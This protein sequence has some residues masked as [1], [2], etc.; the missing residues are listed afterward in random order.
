MSGSRISNC[1][2]DACLFNLIRAACWALP[3][4]WTLT[5]VTLSLS[6]RRT[7]SGCN[8][9]ISYGKPWV[10]FKITI[11]TRQIDSWVDLEIITISIVV[12]KHIQLTNSQMSNDNRVCQPVFENWSAVRITIAR[13]WETSRFL[14]QLRVHTLMGMANG[15][16][17]LS[18]CYY[19]KL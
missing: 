3:G 19:S 1:S 13:W 5:V 16:A 17:S 15:W 10:N 11:D 8:A 12:L 4:K 18:T 9:I 14:C 6:L 7:S 2:S